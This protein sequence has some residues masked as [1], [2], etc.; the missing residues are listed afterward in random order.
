MVSIARFRGLDK[1]TLAIMQKIIINY[2]RF[3]G[4]LAN[5][6]FSSLQDLVHFLGQRANILLTDMVTF[7]DHQLPKTDRDIRYRGS[8]TGYPILGGKFMG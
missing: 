3:L 7:R 6:H 1:N 2:S 8:V 4:I 5:I